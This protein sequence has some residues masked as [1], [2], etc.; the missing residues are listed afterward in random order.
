MTVKGIPG[1]IATI[2]RQK[3]AKGKARYTFYTL[4]YSLL[5]KLKRKTFADLAD[6]KTAGQDAISRIAEGQQGDP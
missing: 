3:Q 4:A 5:G 1:I 6:A 2:Y